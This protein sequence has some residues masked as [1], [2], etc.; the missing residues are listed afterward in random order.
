MKSFVFGLVLFWGTLGFGFLDS[1]F[2]RKPCP[3]TQPGLILR[4]LDHPPSS[5][6]VDRE[7]VVTITENGDYSGTL[8]PGINKSQAEALAVQLGRV[9]PG[10][11][12]H[13]QAQMELE[14]APDAAPA[15]EM[16]QEGP[17]GPRGP[18]GYRGLPGPLPAS[19]AASTLPQNALGIVLP[20]GTVI[21]LKIINPTSSTTVGQARAAVIT[22]PLLG[23]GGGLLIVPVFTTSY[24]LPGVPYLQANIAGWIPC[25]PQCQ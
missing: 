18:R 4:D 3:V 16:M 10:R 13:A 25:P 12:F 11:G 17:P 1:S 24:S 2:L 19:V 15:A 6:P 20:D 14:P 8:Q 22:S 5:R 9:F 21:P 7:F 23:N